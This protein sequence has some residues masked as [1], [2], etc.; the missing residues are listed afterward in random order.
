MGT[1]P[2]STMLTL[3]PISD[4]P[5]HQRR[6][7]GSERIHKFLWKSGS[8]PAQRRVGSHDRDPLRQRAR[9]AEHDPERV[10][11]FL[12]RGGRCSGGIRRT[13]AAARPADE[14][15]R[16]V[17]DHAHDVGC[18]IGVRAEASFNS[19]RRVR[20]MRAMRARARGPG[21]RPRTGHGRSRKDKGGY[22]RT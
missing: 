10:S 8:R 2:V 13:G 17:A 16:D 1:L 19:C 4:R 14:L 11:R 5:L 9:R 3:N 6:R 15:G 18:L 7:V 20:A 22:M 21:R 12:R